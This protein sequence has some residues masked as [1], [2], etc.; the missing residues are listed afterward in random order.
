MYFGA[1]L[2]VQPDEVLV[3]ALDEEGL[4]GHWTLL[5][6]P[7]REVAGSIMLPRGLVDTGHVRPDAK[8]ADMENP[9]ERDSE[10]QLEREDVGVE[11]VQGTVTV[12]GNAKNRG[13]AS[14]QNREPPRSA[15][16]IWML[17]PI[18][19]FVTFKEG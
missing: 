4:P 18:E 6:P 9:G 13:A 15:L 5:C 1:R 7:G 17:E 8:V 19:R 11:P 12:S 2:G 16:P 3:V 10:G 14:R